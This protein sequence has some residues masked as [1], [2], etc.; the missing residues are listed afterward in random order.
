MRIVDNHKCDK[1][2][3]KFYVILNKT[4]IK[5]I[6]KSTS[7]ENN[8]KGCL[9]KTLTM[10]N[11]IEQVDQI[12]AMILNMGKENVGRRVDSVK[13]NKILLVYSKNTLQNPPDWPLSIFILF[14]KLKI[15]MKRLKSL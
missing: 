10:D 15:Q 4:I 5:T 3:H 12:L 7:N 14:F 8:P 2:Q 1:T 11:S 9:L 6:V 13:V